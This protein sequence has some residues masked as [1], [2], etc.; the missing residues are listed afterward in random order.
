M[1]PAFK[2]LIGLAVAVAL[3][4][5]WVIVQPAAFLPHERIIISLPF[6]A[7]NDNS[8][9]M[10]PMGETLFHPKP[11]DPNGHPGIDFQWNHSADIIASADGTVANI[12]HGST[13][14]IDVIVSNGVYELRY[15]EMNETSLGSN[16]KIGAQIK[17]GDFIGNPYESLFPDGSHQYQI[18]WELASISLVLDRWCPLT[19]FDPDSRARIE[20]IWNNVSPDA[21]QGVKRQFPYICS[22]DYFNKQE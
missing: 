10:I 11:K 19:Y 6:S 5:G 4:L 3:F 7:E 12:N 18:H 17:K 22:G 15:K 8:T 9:G 16:I 21:D 2:V 1:R 14:G 20:K 13:E